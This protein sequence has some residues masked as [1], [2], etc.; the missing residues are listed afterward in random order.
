MQKKIVEIQIKDLRLRAIIGFVDWEREQKQD[1]V[2]SYSYK[3]DAS[4]AISSDNISNAADYKALTKNIICIVET[5]K[6][7]LLETLSNKI[8]EVIS[9]NKQL[10]DINVTVEKPG[11]LRF[12]DNVLIK[13]TSAE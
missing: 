9:E 2:I 6:F 10:F 8:H 3:Y 11:A 4:K 5:S 7:N 1:V 12:A 13:I